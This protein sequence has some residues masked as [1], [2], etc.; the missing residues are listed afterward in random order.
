[1]RKANETGLWSSASRIL[2][3]KGQREVSHKRIRGKKR[4]DNKKIKT[5]YTVDELKYRRKGKME[6]TI[7]CMMMMMMMMMMMKYKKPLTTEN[8]RA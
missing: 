8:K 3:R 4:K 6:D 1:M 5:M 7:A 2:R